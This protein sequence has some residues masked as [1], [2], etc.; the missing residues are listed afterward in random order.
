V[1]DNEDVGEVAVEGAAAEVD[2]AEVDAA[3]VDAAE[4]DAAEVDAAEVDAAEV[5]T[6]GASAG[7]FGSV[8]DVDAFD[9]DSAIGALSLAGSM[10]TSE[11]SLFMDGPILH[12]ALS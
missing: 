1:G 7:A 11:S 5:D 8:D 2:A 6:V 3:E 4:V 10:G 9:K 12:F